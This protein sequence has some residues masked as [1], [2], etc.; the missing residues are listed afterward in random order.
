MINQL[1]TQT[2]WANGLATKYGHQAIKI[3]NHMNLQPMK[4]VFS[5]SQ[6]SRREYEDVFVIIKNIHSMVVL[7]QIALKK[8]Q[9]F[10]WNAVSEYL[11]SLTDRFVESRLMIRR[12]R[13]E[14]QTWTATDGEIQGLVADV[15]SI[16]GEAMLHLANYRNA[17]S[18]HDLD[19]YL[20]Q[21]DLLFIAAS[22]V[23]LKLEREGRTMQQ[24]L[25]EFVKQGDET[26]ADLAT[27]HMGP[28]ATRIRDFL[29]QAL[30]Q[31]RA[32]TSH[33][34]EQVREAQ[35]VSNFKDTFPSFLSRHL[36]C[37]LGLLHRWP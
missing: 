10:R 14:R 29:R 32:I 11:T 21:V 34:D 36:P 5:A 22:R 16:G 28:L 31:T 20:E 4:S 7:G 18:G 15:Q 33:H 24:L 8:Q 17:G 2:F 12:L 35:A 6:P 23:Q 25:L 9:D 1:F 13:D 26:R 30:E 19:A 37:I 3:S 27:D